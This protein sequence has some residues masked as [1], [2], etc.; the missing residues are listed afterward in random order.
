MLFKN[1]ILT[2][3]VFVV[4]AMPDMTLGQA[5]PA[6]NNTDKNLNKLTIQENNFSC[7]QDLQCLKQNDP[8]KNSNL[9]EM[10]I[11]NNSVSKYVIEGSSRN[12]EIYAE[13]NRHGELIT[14]TV[15]QRNIV[16][17]IELREILV[18]DDFNSWQMIGNELVVE[19]FDKRSMHYKIILQKD[20]VT[21]IATFDR[22]GN[23]T[24]Q[25]L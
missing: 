16:L 9:D 14:A 15:I 8:F 1:I 21:R 5:S 25:L 12:E 10:R 24:N 7:Y 4:T 17:P 20:G 6:K 19:D 2:L 13:Y 11:N 22:N 3:L 23:I 18:S